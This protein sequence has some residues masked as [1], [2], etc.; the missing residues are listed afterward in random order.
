MTLEDALTMRLGFEWDEWSLPYTDPNNDL[1]AL[2][3]RNVD[4][5][6]ALLD[7]P[8]VGDP[9]TIYRYNTAATTAIGQ[10]VQNATRMPLADLANV[11][12]F[13]SDADSER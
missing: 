9:G 6:K 1:V 3:S 5:A 12:F 8:M 4:W 10:V 13:L 7:L 2:N 11:S